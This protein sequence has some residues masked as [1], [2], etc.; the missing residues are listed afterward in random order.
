M[1]RFTRLMLH[2]SVM[3]PLILA[4]WSVTTVAAEKKFR[5][6]FNTGSGAMFSLETHTGSVNVV[7]G[8]NG[9]ILVE[10]VVGGR[11]KDVEDFDISAEQTGNEVNVRGMLRDKDNWI[12]YSPRL[13]VVFTVRVPREC[14][15]KLKTTV[16]SI[17]VKGVKGVLK[18]GTST[19]DIAIAGTEGNVNLKTSS[20]SIEADSCSGTINMSTF[21][22]GVTVARIEGDVDVSSSAGEISLTGVSGAIRAGTGGGNMT[23]RLA[24]PNHGIHAES[25]GGDIRISLPRQDSGDIDAEASGGEVTCTFAEHLE[26]TIHRDEIDARWN[27]GGNPVY[28]HTTGGDV[29]LVSSE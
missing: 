6:S 25:S 21:G 7:A 29:H 20:G 13:S 18:G 19:G 3:T 26:G 14:G 5:K 17:R 24:G 2:A 15:L 11:D 27:G 9:D 23:L 22:G 12:W 10:A 28:A 16:G 8:E 4:S 1:K